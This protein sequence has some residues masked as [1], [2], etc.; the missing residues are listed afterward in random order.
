[1]ATPA[2]SIMAAQPQ[3]ASP[4]DLPLVMSGNFG[5]LR[6][7]HF[8]SGVDFKTNARTGYP[9]KS[10]ADGYVSRIV[11]S[12]WGFGRA[13][14]V[15]HPQLGLV[16]VY[17]HL[18]AFAPGIKKRVDKIHYQIE[19]FRLDTVF[20]AGELP[21]RA[22]QVIGRS[23]N[24][25]SSGGP[26]LHMDVRDL[27]TGHA[28]DPLVY[29]K[30]RVKDD[31]APEV[32]GIALYPR[33]GVV[34]GDTKPV[35]HTAQQSGEPFTAWGRVV[36]AIKAYDK[37]TGTTNIY[38]VKYMT[39]M[40][41]GDTVYHR[42]IDRVDFDRTRAVNTLVEYG[43]VVDFNSWYM[44][45]QVPDSRPLSSMVTSRGDG[46]LEI[47]EEKDYMC[48][49]VLEDEHGNR[50]RSRFTIKGVPHAI[51]V[52][53]TDAELWLY[54][55]D[56]TAWQAGAKAFF[57][58]N[59]LYNDM[60]VTL[61]TTPATEVEYYSDMVTVGDARQPLAGSYTLSIPVKRT[62]GVDNS[63]YLIARIGSRTPAS[64]GG[65][66]RDGS[67][68]ADV[69]RMGTYA[70]MVDT[71]AP[72]ITVV[73]TP[74]RWSQTGTIKYRIKDNLAGIE[75]YR[76]EIDGK[77]VMFELDGKTGTLSYKMDP[78]RHTRG[79]NHTIKLTVT[80]GVG[81][82]TTRQDILNW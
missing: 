46:V 8:H 80:D 27:A 72:E 34:D 64:V 73:G 32:R 50:R 37:M 51:P 79:S 4:L 9:V 6:S 11:V 54:D 76:G 59:T 75:S 15:T 67:M 41:E 20:A 30:N 69:N 26:H 81:N 60:A 61:V 48:E 65:K 17:G 29:F 44:I 58:A 5:E 49:F 57:P 56:N 78:A 14:Y 47:F 38:G 52:D 68:V 53:D 25:G 16:T 39:F 22:G 33:E 55:R 1:M 40:C 45:T 13:V 36:P 10:V 42:V 12:P 19:S 35:Y 31:V 62:A 77:W 66:Y 82:V 18:E 7:N 74:A 63:R 21:V 43:D 3:L 71:I 2:L 24:A 28:L 70:V 23:G